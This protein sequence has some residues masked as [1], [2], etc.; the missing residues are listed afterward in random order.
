[1][2]HYYGRVKGGVIVLPP[3]V[4]LDE[5]IIVEIRI[6]TSAQVA[7]ADR[8]VGDAVKQ[9]LL[10][11]GLLTEIKDT[12]AIVPARDRTPITIEGK[13]LSELIVEDRR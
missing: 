7:D 10:E 12:A 8:A 2:S 1:M 11:L 9:R 4:A 6:A 5:G 3:N 13:P